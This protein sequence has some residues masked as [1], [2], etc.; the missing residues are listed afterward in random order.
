MRSFTKRRY[1]LT[2]SLFLSKSVLIFLVADVSL[3]VF[4]QI[5]TI[6]IFEW[7]TLLK[8]FIIIKNKETK[9]CV[10]LHIYFKQKRDIK[11]LLN[12]QLSFQCHKHFLVLNKKQ[13]QN[14]W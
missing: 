12:D 3:K 13:H 1:K 14:F 4:Y 5:N 8:D 2:S 10:S 9:I 6:R 11:A 7:M